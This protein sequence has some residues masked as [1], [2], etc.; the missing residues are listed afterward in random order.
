[1]PDWLETVKL[2]AAIQVAS[3]GQ[4]RHALVTSVDAVSHAVKVSI[5]PDGIE[6][7]WVP[8]S[9][10]A[11]GGL[12]IAC[13]AEIGSQVVVVPVEG[14][15]EHPVIVGRLFDVSIVPPTSPATGLPVQPGEFG[16]FLANGSYLHLT[17]DAIFLSGKVVLNGNLSADGDLVAGGISLQNHVHGQVQAGS[18]L[19]GKAILAND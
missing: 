19:S 16:I 14:D 12:R 3:L 1:M 11:V 18:G 6:S 7:G 13:P 17:K 2:H 4:P 15:P 5:Q 8:D 10:L 9:A